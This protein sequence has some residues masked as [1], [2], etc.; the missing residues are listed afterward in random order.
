MQ[1]PHQ[2]ALDAAGFDCV[3][4][5]NWLASGRYELCPGLTSLRSGWSGLWLDILGQHP[6][7]EQWVLLSGRLLG[8]SGVFLQQ[9]WRIPFHLY[10]WVL[11]CLFSQLKNDAVPG[12][13]F[14][15]L[16]PTNLSTVSHI[17]RA[18]WATFTSSTHLW[19]QNFHEKT[20]SCDLYKI[21]FPGW[22]IVE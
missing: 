22:S 13:F 4:D 12:A 8:S 17:W 19:T 11:T 6:K 2:H 15:S 21:I 3:W 20:A 5:P 10:W 14:V 9:W 16:H 1:T 7:M 18:R